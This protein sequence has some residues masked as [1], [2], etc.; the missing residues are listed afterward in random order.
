MPIAT[1]LD[2]ATKGAHCNWLKAMGQLTPHELEGTL[3]MPFPMTIDTPSFLAYHNS[4][5]VSRDM[6]VLLT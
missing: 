4:M 2:G 1:G 3:P 5:L 6:P